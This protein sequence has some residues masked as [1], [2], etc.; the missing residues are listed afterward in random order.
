MLC[1]KCARYC[2]WV[3]SR[4]VYGLHAWVYVCLEQTWNVSEGVFGGLGCLAL[5]CVE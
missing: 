1:S 3:P 5:G 2:I 4:N